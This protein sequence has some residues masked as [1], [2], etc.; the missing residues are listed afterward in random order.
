VVLRRPA[1]PPGPRVDSV[2][3]AL[4]WLAARLAANGPDRE[5]EETAG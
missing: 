3:A 1:T 2:A 5:T 4:D